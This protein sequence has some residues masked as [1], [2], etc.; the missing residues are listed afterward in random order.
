MKKILALVCNLVAARLAA[1]RASEFHDE[2]LRANQGAPA[3]T[4]SPWRALVG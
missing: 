4:F 3:P 1:A 2:S